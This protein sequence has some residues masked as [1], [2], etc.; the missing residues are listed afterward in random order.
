MVDRKR[1]PGLTDARRWL[2]PAPDGGIVDAYLI[3]YDLEKFNPI[4]FEVGDIHLPLEVGRSVV[5]RQAEFFFGRLAA[6]RALE[7]LGSEQLDVSIGSHRQPL[8]PDDFVGSITHSA[9]HAAALVLR[10]GRWNAVGIDIENVSETSLQGLI[11]VVVD[12]LELSYLQTIRAALPISTLVLLVF[13]AKEAF[14]KAAFSSVGRYFDF[15]SVRV[16]GIDFAG[17]QLILQLQ[18]SLAKN[19]IAGAIC[20]INFGFLDFNILFSVCIW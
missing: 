12:H 16:T 18:E 19:L 3:R 8:W 6:K 2:L 1:I 7:N 14:F 13:S 17:G 4:A 5:K 20:T 9:G 10:K 15:S 11:D